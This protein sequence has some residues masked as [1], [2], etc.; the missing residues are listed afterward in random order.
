MPININPGDLSVDNAKLPFREQIDFFLGKEGLKL[1]TEYWDDIKGEE[2]DTAFV[3]A[4]AQKADLLSDFYD[5]VLEAID[6]GQTLAWFQKEFDHIVARHGW[7]HNGAADW[8]ARIIY[9]TN[10]SVSYAKGRDEQLADPDLR[11]ALPF[12]TYHLGNSLHHRAEHAAWDGLTL[13][14]D[15]PFWALHDPVKAWGCNCWKSAAAGPVEGK[16]TAPREQY[17]EHVDRWGEVHTLPKGVDYGWDRS[18]SKWK[19]DLRKYPE[20]IAKSL[21]SDI[22]GA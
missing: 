2:H 11:A 1:P 16:S 14:W 10:L 21:K 17:Y 12:C 15:H 6:E 20:P 4:G 5:A 3:V 18:G 22:D 7:E 9:Q 19:P 8:R 13:P